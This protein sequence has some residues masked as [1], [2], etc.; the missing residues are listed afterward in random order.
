MHDQLY[1]PVGG[2][3]DTPFYRPDLFICVT[4]PHRV[5]HEQRFYPGDVCFRRGWAG[6]WAERAGLAAGRTQA[7]LPR[8]LLPMP[9]LLVMLP[10]RLLQ[11]AHPYSTR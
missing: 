11:V 9:L 2:N 10:P 8:L 1:T 7:S 4:D 6:V 5:G 3:N